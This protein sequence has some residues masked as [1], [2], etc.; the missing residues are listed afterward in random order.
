MPSAVG[1]SGTLVAS[2]G[3]TGGITGRSTLPILARVL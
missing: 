1:I 3:S 2:I